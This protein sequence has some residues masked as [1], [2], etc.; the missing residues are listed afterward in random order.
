ML[1]RSYTTSGTAASSIT[2][3]NQTS[4]GS[5]GNGGNG[6]YYAGTL[7]NPAVVPS[8]AEGTAGTS[9]LGNG[10]AGKSRYI[11]DI[12]TL[13]PVTYTWQSTSSNSFTFTTSVSNGSY[14]LTNVAFTLAGGG[15]RVSGGSTGAEGAGGLG[16]VFTA[17][18]KTPTTGTVFVLQ[19]GQ[20]GQVYAGSANAASS[21]TGGPGGEIGRA[22]V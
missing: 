9:P 14:K 1:F 16:S 21:A 3:I 12:V 20:A 2:I 13:S 10:S 17:S 19:P 11:S 6:P 22:H 4:S 5:G 18:L 15:G 7:V 8:G